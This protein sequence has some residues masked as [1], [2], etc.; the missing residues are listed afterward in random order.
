M[1]NKDRQGCK[2]S[3]LPAPLNVAG[4]W[5]LGHQWIP[6]TD[7]TGVSRPVAARHATGG[8]LPRLQH[9]TDAA[10]SS[11][12]NTDS[13]APHAHHVPPLVRPIADRLPTWRSNAIFL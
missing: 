2:L 10:S 11:L 7:G 5:H 1:Q 9:R 12:A 4:R 8:H 3:Y 6:R 13:G